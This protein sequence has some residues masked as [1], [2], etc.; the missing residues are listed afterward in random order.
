MGP[1]GFA[2][3][4]LVILDKFAGLSFI[5]L[6]IYLSSEARDIFAL[7]PTRGAVNGLGIICL[8]LL[9]FAVVH[10]PQLGDL[11]NVVLGATA[12]SASVDADS[13]PF[14][15]SVDMLFTLTITSVLSIKN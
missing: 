12:G 5:S 2:V 7:K 11:V 9:I 14:Y 8:S 15:V 1:F 6:L 10:S 3:I 13:T 4:L